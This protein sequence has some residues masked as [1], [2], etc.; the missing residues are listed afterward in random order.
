VSMNAAGDTCIV[1]AY[2]DNAGGPTDAGAAYIFERSGGVWGEAAK[3]QASDGEVSAYFGYSASMNAAGDTCIVGAY[4]DNAGFTDAGAAY[5]FTKSGGV[6][7]EA[8]KISASDAEASAYFGYSVSMN[9]AGDT[10][11]VGAYLD[12][13]G[14]LN[15]AGAAYTFLMPNFF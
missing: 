1:G 6:W 3:L 12:N 9:A 2:L 8:A 14:G 11:I 10:C 5:I 15:D 4:G 7:S 13:A